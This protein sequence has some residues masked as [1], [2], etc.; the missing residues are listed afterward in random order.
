[1]RDIAD[2][3]DQEDAE[4]QPVKQPESPRTDEEL[5]AK[6]KGQLLA[7]TETL[8]QLQGRELNIDV[9]LH[10]DDCDHWFY[11]LTLRRTTYL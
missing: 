7:A 2:I 10:S 6:L 3:L 4:R 11:R 8:N 1:M 9:S 5:A